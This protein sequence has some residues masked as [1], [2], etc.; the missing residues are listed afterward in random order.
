MR[1]KDSKAQIEVWDWK[2]RAYKEVEGLSVDAALRERL[3]T[4]IDTTRKLGLS[5]SRPATRRRNR[6]SE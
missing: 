2:D 3:A 4:C 1:S 5:V 6:I